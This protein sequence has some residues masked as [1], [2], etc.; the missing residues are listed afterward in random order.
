MRQMQ[1][2]SRS[3]SRGGLTGAGQFN[4]VERFLST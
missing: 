2:V 4:G 3:Q 1:P